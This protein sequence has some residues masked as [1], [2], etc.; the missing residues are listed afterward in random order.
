ME[1]LLRM[2]GRRGLRDAL[3][4]RTDQSRAILVQVL[5]EITVVQEGNGAIYAEFD[6]PAH[7]LL[8]AAGG[9]VF[10]DGSGGRI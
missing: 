4:R 3:E 8:L 6:D 10:P 5:G 2:G 9:G 1:V 7:R